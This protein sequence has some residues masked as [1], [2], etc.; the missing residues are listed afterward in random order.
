MSLVREKNLFLVLSISL[1]VFFLCYN[2]IN[3]EEKI[4]IFADEVR[5]DKANEKVTATGNA[6][7]VNEDDIKIKSDL[8]IYDKSINYLE[9]NGNVIIND[10]T[11]NTFL[12][13]LLLHSSQSILLIFQQK[14]FYLLH[15][16]IILFLIENV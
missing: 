1:V 3:A 7:A 14:V 8:L 6:V 13:H 2:V 12:H 5:V 10:Q 11:K 4:K 16:L 9:A 15:Q